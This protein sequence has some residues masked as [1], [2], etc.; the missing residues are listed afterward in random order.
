M[1]LI[2]LKLG[3][4]TNLSTRSSNLKVDFIIYIIM[5]HF[6]VIQEHYVYID[7][8]GSWLFFTNHLC[9]IFKQLD[10]AIKR[11]VVKI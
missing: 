7:Y 1:G 4:L 10:N 6:E 2:G 9:C 3:K 11:N 5:T 8:G